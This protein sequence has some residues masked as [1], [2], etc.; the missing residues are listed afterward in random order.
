MRNPSK[1]CT[2]YLGAGQHDHRLIVP[3]LSHVVV[4]T[5]CLGLA[6]RRL[7][8]GALTGAMGAALC[9]VEEAQ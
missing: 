3:C 9:S 8:S 6:V 1:W 2:R 7:G 4:S 5:V